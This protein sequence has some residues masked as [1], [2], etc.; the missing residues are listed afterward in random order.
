MSFFHASQQQGGSNQ[1]VPPG[2]VA[3]L[4]IPWA[5]S[6]QTDGDVARVFHA[7]GWGTIS[8]IDLVAK[9]TKRPH[10]TVYIHFSSW[11]TNNDAEHAYHNLINLGNDLKVFY[12]DSYFWK[13]R[14]SN[15]RPAPVQVFIPRVEI[16]E[17]TVIPQRMDAVSPE[18][19]QLP[20]PLTPMSLEDEAS[21]ALEQID[22]QV[23]MELSA[24]EAEIEDTFV[25][26]ELTNC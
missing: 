24:L 20:S 19:N 13:V 4:V 23:E 2:T 25:N 26:G 15:W 11:N 8:K 1:V 10:N 14:R 16:I 9:N 7:L 18:Y 6:W 12:N 17:P 22:M 5:E 21:E 3:S